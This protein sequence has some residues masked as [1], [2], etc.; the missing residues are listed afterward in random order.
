[1]ESQFL[2]ACAKGELEVVK[3]L[4]E[5]P[6]LDV[7]VKD[8]RFNGWTP[9]IHA[10]E[11]SHFDV[12]EVLLNDQRIDI[13]GVDNDGYTALSYACANG[14]MEVVKFLLKYENLNINKARKLSYTPIMEACYCDHLDIVDLILKS[15]K[16][17]NTRAK[18]NEGKTVLDVLKEKSAEEKKTWET[19]ELFNEKKTRYCDTVKLL[20]LLDGSL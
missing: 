6:D 11:N 1:M 12:M 5:N 10:C 15:G 9:F 7:N 16:K 13:N 18:D 3:K 20:E 2:D 8:E 17:I 14:N 19:E 4:L